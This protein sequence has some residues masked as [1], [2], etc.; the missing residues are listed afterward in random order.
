MSAPQPQPRIVFRAPFCTGTTQRHYP[1]LHSQHFDRDTVDTSGQSAHNPV[2]RKSKE[3]DA[4]KR[5][6]I[7]CG[8]RGNHT[9][10]M[11]CF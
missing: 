5:V 3:N 4:E 8:D 7:T 6:V 10:A 2:S 11:H 1:K 9:R